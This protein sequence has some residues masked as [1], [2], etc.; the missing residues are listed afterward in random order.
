MALL[1]QS[2]KKKYVKVNFVE[3]DEDWKAFEKN[4]EFK[5]LL[6]KYRV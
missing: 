3:E 2:L 4:I 5:A 6:D 1:E